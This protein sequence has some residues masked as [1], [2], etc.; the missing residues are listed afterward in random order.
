MTQRPPPGPCVHCLKHHEEL[1]WDHVFP[2]GWYPDTTPPNL[3]KWQIP[4]CSDCNQTYGT[5]EGD[6]LIRLGLCITPDTPETKGISEKAR[7]SIDP[8]FGRDEKDRKARQRKRESL[9]KEIQEMSALS[10]EGYLPNFGPEPGKVYPA[11]LRVP[12]SQDHLVR[13]GAKLVRG[14]T[15][16]LDGK[17][18]PPEYEIGVYFAENDKVPEPI[19]LLKTHGKSYHRGPGIMVERGIG[20]D[21][22]MSALFIID[23]WGKLRVFASVL[24]LTAR[25]DSTDL[26]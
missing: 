14:L 2:A 3:E 4:A 19:Q 18:I 8:K 9:L 20:V 26:T 22:P 6:L 24:A 1:T 7:R 12:I 16:I 15:Y 11:L 5:L 13:L 21:D 23:I 17:L 25:P 10:E